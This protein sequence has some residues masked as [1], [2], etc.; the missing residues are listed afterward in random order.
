MTRAEYDN[1]SLDE[2]EGLLYRMGSN[3]KIIEAADMAILDG[4]EYVVLAYINGD[5]S[6]LNEYLDEDT[7]TMDKANDFSTQTTTDAVVPSATSG[8]NGQSSDEYARSAEMYM[9]G[10]KLQEAYGLFEQAKYSQALDACAAIIEERGPNY[11]ANLLMA[12]A[13]LLMTNWNNWSENKD[14]FYEA[15]S[16]TIKLT[17]TVEE[18]LEVDYQI[19]H[20]IRVW[21][22]QNH[23]IMLERVR[24][25]TSYETWKAYLTYQQQSMMS[26]ALII[27]GLRNQMHTQNLCEKAGIS[28]DQYYDM[29][30]S[31]V[32][33]FPTDEI[34]SIKYDIACEYFN[35][36]VNAIEENKEAS[37]EFLSVFGQE[38]IRRLYLVDTILSSSIDEETKNLQQLL[39]HL[40]MQANVKRYMLDATLHPNGA[41][42]S[43]IG[44]NRSKEINELKQIYK[45]IEQIDPAFSMP[46]MPEANGIEPVSPMSGGNTSSG[47][48]YVATAVY[49]SYDCPEVWTLRRFRDTILASTWYG[50]AFIRTYYAISPTL[51]K[52]F[53][54]TAWF[55]NLWRGKLN[56][57]VASL[58]KQGIEST[59]Y[60]DI[61]W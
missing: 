23:R 12:R 32:D 58:Q 59:P 17:S 37:K 49:G 22:A 5:S 55:K 26:T 43:L 52:W 41:T 36:T 3:S 48:C 9:D 44:G 21:D 16:N 39:Q 20:S 2:V 47:G 27:M 45:K 50:R 10:G 61:N 11:K 33:V 28:K 46:E 25:N 35:A 53:G 54:H 42:I 57:M 4:N 14:P 6:A 38:A 8:E 24:R 29:C 56:K 13:F 60:N 19:S 34:N 15:A 18:A 7:S 31:V 40:Y 1:L 51:V 30:R